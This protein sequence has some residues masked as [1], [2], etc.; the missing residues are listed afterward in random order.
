MD[1]EI[2]LTNVKIL[3]R[4]LKLKALSGEDTSN[5][6]TGVF[7]VALNMDGTLTEITLSDLPAGS[8][9]S[10]KYEIHK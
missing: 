2:A 5:V 9:E 6:R 7:V 1:G 3:I 4:D 8:Y 10:S